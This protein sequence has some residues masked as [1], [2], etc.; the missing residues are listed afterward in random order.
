MTK[1]TLLDYVEQEFGILPD[2]PF[3]ND[4]ETAVL[5]HKDNKKWFGICMKVH[6]SKLGTNGDGVVDVLNVKCEPML[7]VGLLSTKGVYTAYHMN[8]SHWLSLCLQE[9][10]DENLKT[11]L[12]L[13]FDLT[14]NKRKTKN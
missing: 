14:K 9:I 10:S 8:K 2:F 5:R 3:E 12:S 11:L 6:K 1:Q 4:F 7:R 13:S